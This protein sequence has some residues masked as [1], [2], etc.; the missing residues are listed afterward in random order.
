[1]VTTHPCVH[2]CSKL[3]VPM[4]G[5]CQHCT[6]CSHW[7]C[8]QGRCSVSVCTSFSTFG[9][10]SCRCRAQFNICTSLPFTM[11]HMYQLALHNVSYVQA[12]PSALSQLILY[13]GAGRPRRVLLTPCLQ[14]GEREPLGKAYLELSAD[15]H[16]LL[17]AKYK[18]GIGRIG[19]RDKSIVSLP[20]GG[21]DM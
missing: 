8:G 11:Y 14:V 13:L 9:T 18:Y 5:P 16:A 4:K 15:Y 3:S 2:S 1:M 10:M 6:R 19:S 7:G 21:D 20:W 12:C 17:P